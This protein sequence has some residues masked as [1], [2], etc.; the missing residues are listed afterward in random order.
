MDKEDVYMP[1]S[2]ID[3]HGVVRGPGKDDLGREENLQTNY[4]TLTWPLV[5]VLLITEIVWYPHLYWPKKAAWFLP[6]FAA[7]FYLLFAIIMYIYIGNTVASGLK[8]AGVSC[9]PISSLRARSTTTQPRKSSS[10][11]SSAA[12]YISTTTPSLAGASGLP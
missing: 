12:P 10:S 8:P 3:I 2:D 11:A 7:S 6:T 1:I 4:K 5:T 9:C